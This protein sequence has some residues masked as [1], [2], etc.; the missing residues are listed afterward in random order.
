MLSGQ[1]IKVDQP[2]YMW[3]YLVFVCYL[4]DVLTHK[5]LIVVLVTSGKGH[6]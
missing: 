2:F 3:A 4:P 1:L 6:L 5:D